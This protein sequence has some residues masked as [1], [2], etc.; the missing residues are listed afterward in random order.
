MS[1]Q[2][3]HTA[4]PWR[5]GDMGLTVFGPK[6]EHPAPVTVANLPPPSPRVPA[7]ERAANRALILAAPDLLEALRMLED[8]GLLAS[9]ESMDDAASEDGE[10]EIAG[11]AIRAA[12]AAIAKAEGG[13]A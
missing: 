6:S 4:G 10:A 9:L 12:R 13:A 8:G 5:A 2:V 3:K 11:P 7:A 1:E